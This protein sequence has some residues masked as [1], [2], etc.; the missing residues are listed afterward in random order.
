VRGSARPHEAFDDGTCEA[1]HYCAGP[2]IQAAV[3]L[4]ENDSAVGVAAVSRRRIA[5]IAFFPGVDVTVAAP[6]LLATCGAAAIASDAI[7]VIALLQSFDDS[8][9]TNGFL[10][11]R[12]AAAIARDVVAVVA[13]FSGANGIVSTPGFLDAEAATAIA[14]RGVAVVALLPTLELN[15]TIATTLDRTGVT[16]TITIDEIPVVAFFE[17]VEG[18]I[19][20]AFEE[21]LRATAIAGDPVSVV[22]GFPDVGL[23]V[24]ADARFELT[25]GTATVTRDVA[26]VVALF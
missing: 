6:L 18:A 2:P 20:T 11:A 12:G 15:A 4:K 25:R 14:G 9:A 13:A 21:A 5:V 10:L 8:I 19:P 3:R 7:A 22:A 23:A 24:P 16:A 26:T 17:A 1:P